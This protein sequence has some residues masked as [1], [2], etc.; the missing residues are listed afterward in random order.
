M[1]KEYLTWG[2]WFQEY[3]KLLNHYGLVLIDECHHCASETIA[4]VLKEVK[5]RYV[6]GVTATPKRG[7]GLEKINYMLIGPI[8]YSYTAKEK[9]MEQGIQHLVYPRFT[10]TVPPR[11][12]INGKMHPNEACLLKYPHK[13]C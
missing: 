5:A 7:D 12:V 9:A 4:N 3:H 2:N 10:R 11:G 13:K 6:Y 1:K 8:R